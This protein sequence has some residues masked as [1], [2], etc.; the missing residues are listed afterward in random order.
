[1]RDYILHSNTKFTALGCLTLCLAG[2]S[3]FIN[4]KV[5][6]KFT[7]DKVLYHKDYTSKPFISYEDFF[8]TQEEVVNLQIDDNILNDDGYI[9]SSDDYH[10]L[11]EPEHTENKTSNLPKIPEMIVDY[12]VVTPDKIHNQYVISQKQPLMLKIPEFKTPEIQPTDIEKSEYFTLSD[13]KAQTN[14][15][16][17]PIADAIISFTKSVPDVKNIAV[18]TPKTNSNLYEKRSQLRLKIRKEN[19]KL[20]YNIAEIKKILKQLNIRLED[21]FYTNNNNYFIHDGYF[22]SFDVT[23]KYM[24]DTY[25]EFY[26]N[27]QSF[28]NLKIALSFVPTSPP[29][30]QARLSS[31]FGWRR[32]PFNKRPKLHSGL[33][34]AN[35][36]GTPIYTPASGTVKFAGYKGGYGKCVDVYHGNNVVTRYGHLSRILVTKGQRLL[37]GHHIA[38]LGSTGRSTGPHLHY[39]V[40][41][42]GKAVNPKTFIHVQDKLA[43]LLNMK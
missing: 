1:M 27:L 5:H 22:K 28:Y 19:G 6:S 16:I 37:R 30:K 42:N 7:L 43:P 33:D 17:L 20:I 12:H 9:K 34:F 3:L 35:R 24:Q 10:D 40:I 36:T 41:I 21:K 2:Y 18:N 4:H 11:F 29:V 25:P 38:A 31:G 13:N 14:I 26:K 8:P 39:E 23:P 15:Y 32:D